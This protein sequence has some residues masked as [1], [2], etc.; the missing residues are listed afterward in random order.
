MRRGASIAREVVI[1]TSV[2]ITLKQEVCGQWIHTLPA[3]DQRIDP[4]VRANCIY[5]IF[6][7]PLYSTS[8]PEDISTN[9]KEERRLV[10]ELRR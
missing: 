9:A 4:H 1:R 10:F 6:L 2:A 7:L 5:S 8:L 3:Q